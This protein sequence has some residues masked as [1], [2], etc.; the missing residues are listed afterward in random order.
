MLTFFILGDILGAGIYALTGQVAADVGG[1]IWASFLVSFLLALITAFAYL[2]LVTKYPRAAG[3][4]LRPPGVPHRHPQ[5]HGH[6]RRDG[7]GGHLGLV[8]G[9]P[10]RRPL[11]D[12]R[13]R[14]REP[15]DRAH[16]HPGHPAGGGRTT[17]G[18]GESIKINIAITLIELSGLLFIILVGLK[19]LL[20]GDGD[21]GQAFEFKDSGFGALTGIT[22]GAATAFYAFIGFEDSVNMAEEVRDPVR[23]FPPAL[24][25]GIVA[26]SIIYLLV[27]ITAAMVVPLDV[28]TASTGP[29]L[30]VCT[31]ACP[32]T[33]PAPCSRSSP[34]SRCP[35]PC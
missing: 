2:E 26:A 22:A 1:A 20:S 10:G 9:H 29:L 31:S 27:G 30:E 7:L 19:V 33:T 21:P 16:R 25:T 23:T 13:V 18:V 32:T 12:G 4:A 34:S 14:D 6:H 11:L 17:A 8:R 35:T 5:L 15:A 24:L 3:A 28:L